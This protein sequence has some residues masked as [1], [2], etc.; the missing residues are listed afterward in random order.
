MLRDGL[1]LYVFVSSCNKIVAVPVLNRV[2]W[3]WNSPF[4][5]EMAV[6]TVTET[7][8]DSL[9]L[10]SMHSNMISPG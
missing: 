1:F 5:D 9:L 3:G 10:S 6:G 4:D 8:P 7:T 2:V